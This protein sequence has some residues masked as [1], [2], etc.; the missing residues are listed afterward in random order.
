M[1]IKRVKLANTRY[2]NIAVTFPSTPYLKHKST[3]TPRRRRRRILH[4]NSMCIN[5]SNV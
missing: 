1:H 5:G 4:I 2:A 3:S